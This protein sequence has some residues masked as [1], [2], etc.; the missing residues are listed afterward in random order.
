MSKRSE[1]AKHINVLYDNVR[2]EE[3]RQTIDGA[4]LWEVFD[5]SCGG[6]RWV[7][8]GETGELIGNYETFE[9]AL[10]VFNN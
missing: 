4:I 7:I 10:E 5:K 3:K 9:Q 1:L 8:E 2:I 6:F